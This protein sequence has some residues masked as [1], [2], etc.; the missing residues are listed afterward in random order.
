MPFT[1]G[2]QVASGAGS[3]SDSINYQQYFIEVAEPKQTY[4]LNDYQYVA[5][6]IHKQDY[7]ASITVA[8]RTPDQ[9]RDE[10]RQRARDRELSEGN[11][12]GHPALRQDAE[13]RAELAARRRKV[14]ARPVKAHAKPSQNGVGCGR[15][16]Q[17]LLALHFIGLALGCRRW[18]RPAHSGADHAG[19]PQGERTGPG[20]AHAQPVEERQLR[21]PAADPHRRRDDAAA[22]RERDLP[23][24]RRRVSR[25]AHPGRDHD[26][27]ARLLPGHRRARPALGRSVG[28]QPRAA[29]GARAAG[30]GRACCDCCCGG[31]QIVAFVPVG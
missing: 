11:V 12:L 18:F 4:W 6:D 25:Q 7:E 30:A 8:R 5:H 31:F 14:E 28:A 26:R 19:L 16:Y 20:A 2:G 21:A 9:G 15:M 10:R 23:V 29:D 1:V 22:R 17:V 24:G 13:P 27:R 3:S